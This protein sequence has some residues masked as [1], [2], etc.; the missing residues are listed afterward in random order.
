MGFTNWVIKT[1]F[2]LFYCMPETI[3]ARIGESFCILRAYIAV[4]ANDGALKSQ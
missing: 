3:M 1:I 2:Y 4:K